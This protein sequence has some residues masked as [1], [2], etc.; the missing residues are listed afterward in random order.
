MKLNRLCIYPKDVQRITGKSE[1]A[2]RRLLQVIKAKLG[3]E[4]HQFITT[5]E[6]ALHTGIKEE[7]VRQYLND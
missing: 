7:L 5:E 6:F 1:K 4:G 2:S 3:K